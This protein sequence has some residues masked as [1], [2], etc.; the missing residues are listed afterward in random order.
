MFTHIDKKKKLQFSSTEMRILGVFKAKYTI[1][2]D[3]GSDK[4]CELCLT[5]QNLQPPHINA[6]SCSVQLGAIY[7]GLH[8]GSLKTMFK[9]RHCRYLFVRQECHLVVHP[10]H[11]RVWTH[12]IS[13][14]TALSFRFQ[15]PSLREPEHCITDVGVKSWEQVVRSG[16]WYL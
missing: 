10:L 11:T 3:D 4:D 7:W 5:P 14:Q 1:C 9:Q 8:L 12:L 6:C 13:L 2:T 16:I 15:Q